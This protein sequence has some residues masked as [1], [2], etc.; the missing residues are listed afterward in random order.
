MIYADHNATSPLLPE[1]KD[2][3]ESRMKD[4]AV[5]AN[6]SSLHSLGKNVG[7]AL[8]RCRSIC[9]DLVGASND[10]IFFNSGSSEGITQVFQSVLSQTKKKTII[11]SNQ[12]HAAVE[13]ACQYYEKN[14][15][16]D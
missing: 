8:E 14:G 1:V 7:A 2:Y 16:I 11:T 5:Y 3:L 13:Y 4:N 15:S 12:E 10:Q 9:A 6:P